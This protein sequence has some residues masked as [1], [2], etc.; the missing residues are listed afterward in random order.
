MKWF[1][2]YKQSL[3]TAL[4]IGILAGIAMMIPY[5]RNSEAAIAVFDQRNIEEAVKT[6][7]QTANILS[8]E[9][10]QYAL[11]L[12]NIKK[13]D[14]SVLEDLI[15][16]NQEKNKSILS[17]D[18]IIP[19]G[20]INDPDKSVQAIWDE[21]MGNIEDV[22]N[23]NMTVTD[24]TLQEQKRQ[25]AMHEAAKGTAEAAQQTVKLDAQN[26]KDA[27]AALDASNNAEGQHQAI[28]AGNYLLFN[29]LNSVQ[30]GN[31]SKAYMEAVT[32]AYYDM[33][34]QEKAESDRVLTNSTNI[35]KAW[36]ENI[37]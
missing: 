35:S 29:I 1:S 19:K 24:M 30:N 22:L 28:Q 18:A 16:R 32:A 14:E 34:N 9:Q 26:M 12:L 27:T 17:G 23:G 13:L 11:Q 21:R 4:F 5:S 7:I 2:K 31:R 3:L 10:K 25:Q 36:V 33:K 8:E 37:Q 15:N 20:I 6:A